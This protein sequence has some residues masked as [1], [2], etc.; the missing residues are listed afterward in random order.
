MLLLSLRDILGLAASVSPDA[1]SVKPVAFII[2]NSSLL[3]YFIS[4]VCS[5][6]PLAAVF[7]SKK[8]FRP[9]VEK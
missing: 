8:C 4:G 6:S 3:G 7:T 2:S 9:K 1:F 5:M